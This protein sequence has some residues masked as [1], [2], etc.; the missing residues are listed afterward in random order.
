MYVAIELTSYLVGLLEL[1]CWFG[2][3]L[4]LVIYFVG[5]V[6]SDLGSLSFGFDIFW[7]HNIQSVHVN[8]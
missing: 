7:L 3:E 5:A 8:I 6:N 1:A 2:N 4:S